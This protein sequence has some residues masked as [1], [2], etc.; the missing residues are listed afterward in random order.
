M[1][2]LILEVAGLAALIVAG[3]MVAPVVGVAVAGV[4]LG[5]VGYLLED[6]V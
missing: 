3:F 6:E 2:S 5:L 1:L 4:A